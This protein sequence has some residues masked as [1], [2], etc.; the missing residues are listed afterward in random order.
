MIREATVYFARTIATTGGRQSGGF[1]GY[2][3]VLDGIRHRPRWSLGRWVDE[4]TVS[5]G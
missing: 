1:D 2:F 3:G 4:L 5:G